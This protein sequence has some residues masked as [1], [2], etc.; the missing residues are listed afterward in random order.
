MEKFKL[1]ILTG[2]LILVV[3]PLCSQS[4]IPSWKADS[5]LSELNHPNVSYGFNFNFAFTELNGET[6]ASPDSLATMA[7]S[8]LQGKLTGAPSD[9]KIY[10]QLVYRALAQKD[11]EKV[12][13]ALNKG[14]TAYQQYIEEN[15]DDTSAIYGL[16]SMMRATTNYSHAMNALDYGISRY[17][18]HIPFHLSR[19][20]VLFYDL[21]KMDIAS[22]YIDSLLQEFPDAG[23]LVYMGFMKAYSSHM[24]NNGGE[25]KSVEEVISPVSHYLK[26]QPESDARRFL[27]HFCRTY[28]YMNI[29]AVN[30]KNAGK[31][32]PEIILGD[33]DGFLTQEQIE[34]LEESIKFLKG[35]RKRKSI[36]AVLTAKSQAMA[37]VILGRAKDA[38]K[39][40]IRQ[41]DLIQD[42]SRRMAV[43]EA[44]ALLQIIKAGKDRKKSIEIV[45]KKYESAPNPKDLVIISF[46]YYKDG[47]SQ[48][49][50]EFALKANKKY[51]N[52]GAGWEMMAYLQ[53]RDGNTSAAKA[54]IDKAKKWT[55]DPVYHYLLGVAY[56]AMTDGV[57]A[58]QQTL[59][60]L[61]DAQPTHKKALKMMEVLKS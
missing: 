42:E 47:Q 6:M 46:M 29:K 12:L 51:P 27:Y 8:E 25:I 48:Q 37:Y 14:Y 54:A 28:I 36:P 32:G 43:E 52:L 60:K 21:G 19:F 34:G 58:A 31:D 13:N 9:A 41:R 5:L 7:E 57:E 17:P 10:A 61:L 38:E 45:K 11:Q 59:Q 44:I 4:E 26:R 3:K 33:S 18:Q 23:E 50:K 30:A 39:M 35:A 22:Q 20:Q 1:F 56:E 53:L 49:A 24:M 16:A 2:I 40:L 15:P 55:E